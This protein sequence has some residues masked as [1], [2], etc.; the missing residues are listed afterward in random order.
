MTAQTASLP[1]AAETTGSRE[2]AFVYPSELIIGHGVT[3]TL[4]GGHRCAVYTATDDDAETIRDMVRHKGCTATS[5]D[6]TPT[7]EGTYSR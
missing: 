4:P 1:A 3:V 7:T 6:Y 5:F 2:G